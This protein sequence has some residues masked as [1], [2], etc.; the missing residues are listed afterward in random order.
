[1]DQVKRGDVVVVPG[2]ATRKPRPA[3]VVHAD[4]FNDAH[5]S[6]TRVPVTTTLVDTPLFRLTIEPS[7]GNGLRALSHVMIDKVTTVARG[8]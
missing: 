4:V 5:P 7:P 8:R 1:V 6:V 3:L 2:P